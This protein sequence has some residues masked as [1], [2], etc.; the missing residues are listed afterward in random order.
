MASFHESLPYFPWEVNALF[1]YKMV[2]LFDIS[3]WTGD[4]EVEII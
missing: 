1:M 3:S 4:E 2:H